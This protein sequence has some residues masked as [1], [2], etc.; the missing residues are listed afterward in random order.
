MRQKQVTFLL[1]MLLLGCAEPPRPNVLLFLVD[2]LGWTDLGCYGSDLYETPHI[3]RLAAEGVRF[4]QAYSACTVCSPTRAALMTGKSPAQLHLTDWIAG[5]DRPDA[6]LA[7]PDWTQYLPLE[8]TTLAELLQEAGYATASIGKWHLGDDSIYYPQHQGFDLNV[9]GYKRGQP[10]SYFAPYQNKRWPH[11]PYLAPGDSGEYLTDRLTDEA[12][13]FIEGRGEKPFFL[14][15]PHYAVHTPLQAP[16]SLVAYYEGKP[17]DSLRHQN[18]TY[19]AMIHSTDQS[20]GRLLALLEERGELDHTLVIFASDNGG[21]E[22]RDVT[23]NAPLRAG[24]GSAYEGGTRT[25]FIL[26]LP[27]GQ[28]AGSETDLP[29][30]SMD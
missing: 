7:P 26:R 28:R 6:P 23:E 21:L 4:T 18:A 9:A 29:A 11:I 17:R 16:D 20:M 25:P 30:I 27:D 14:Y 15:L 19:A 3:D 2:D 1:G 8:E 12:I 5:H 13:R 24:K 10:P 22:L